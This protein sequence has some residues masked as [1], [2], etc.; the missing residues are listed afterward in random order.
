MVHFQL[1]DWLATASGDKTIKIWKLWS[2][3]NSDSIISGNRLGPD[4]DTIITTPSQVGKVKWR[5]GKKTQIA[6]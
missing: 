3:G 4:E 2:A 1:G 5:P 6:R